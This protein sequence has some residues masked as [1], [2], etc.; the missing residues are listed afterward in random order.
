MCNF[1][2]YLPSSDSVTFGINSSFAA[3]SPLIFL[4]QV[5]LHKA[6]FGEGGIFL[7]MVEKQTHLTKTKGSSLP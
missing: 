3:P 6:R 7:R 5:K 1:S 2:L 4:I